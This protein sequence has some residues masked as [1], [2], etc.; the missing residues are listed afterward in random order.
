MEDDS[1][2]YEILELMRKNIETKSKNK[3]LIIEE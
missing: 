2:T 1:V 3:G